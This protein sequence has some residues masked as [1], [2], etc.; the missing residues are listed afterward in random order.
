MCEPVPGAPQSPVAAGGA[1]ASRPCTEAP[2]QQ[3][4]G[5][6]VAGTLGEDVAPVSGISPEGR[7]AG[8][9]SSC[10]PARDT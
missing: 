1:A 2:G 3:L 6:R 5:G 8:A 7:R 9:A 10:S 4:P